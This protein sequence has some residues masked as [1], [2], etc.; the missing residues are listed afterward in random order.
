[1]KYL[2][3]KVETGANFGYQAKELGCGPSSKPL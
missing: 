3:E 2:F 1:M